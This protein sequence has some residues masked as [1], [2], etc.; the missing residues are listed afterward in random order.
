[1]NTLY[2]ITTLDSIF[3]ALVLLSIVSVFAIIIFSCFKN[4]QSRRG[5]TQEELNRDKKIADKWLVPSIL[6]FG[7]SLLGSIFIP[8][9]KN[10]Y[11]I[12]GI[13]GTIDYLKENKDAKKLPDKAVKALN[14]FIDNEIRKDS[15][16]NE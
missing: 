6:I 4:P 16:Q 3:I 12:Y 11:I 9:T 14:A 5:Y 8:S 10:A 2:W 13:G 7:I 1:M 15:T